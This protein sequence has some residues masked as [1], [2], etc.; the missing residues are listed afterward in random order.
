MA[1]ADISKTGADYDLPI[2]TGIMATPC[3]TLGRLPD[4][5]RTIA[6]W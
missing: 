6:R 5:G 1:P 3:Y 2:A 4:D